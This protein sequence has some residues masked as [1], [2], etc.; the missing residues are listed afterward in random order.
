MKK[1]TV[2]SIRS[3]LYASLHNH[4]IAIDALI[5]AIQTQ[6]AFLGNKKTWTRKIAIV[7]NGHGAIEQED[8]ELTVDKINSL[9]IQ[10]TVL[11][12]K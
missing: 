9:D 2:S 12:G 10:L 8:W 4:G 1:G 5:V 6:D 7:T 3:S 11:S